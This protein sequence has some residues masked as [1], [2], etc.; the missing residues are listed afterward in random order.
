MRH[1]TILS[2]HDGAKSQMIFNGVSYVNLCIV[3]SL[4]KL[5]LTVCLVNERG[6]I[7]RQKTW[8]EGIDLFTL[9]TESSFFCIHIKTETQHSTFRIRYSVRSY[10]SV[11]NFFTLEVTSGELDTGALISLPHKWLSILKIDPE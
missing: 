4:I 7:K 1:T 3:R 5:L 9:M 2:F 11:L 6:R 10:D 8:K